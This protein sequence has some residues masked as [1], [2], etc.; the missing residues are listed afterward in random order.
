MNR[1]WLRIPLVVIVLLTGAYLLGP[2]PSV[3]AYD[4]VLPPV[5]A[6]PAALEKYVQARESRH[7]LKPDNEAQITWQD[8][9][10]RKT[11]YSIVYLHGFSASRKEGEPVAPDFAR[12]YGCNL[13]MSRLDGHGIDTSEP[14]LG[15]T[16]AGLWRDA[17][18]ALGIGQTLGHK[19]IV[20][21]TSTGGTLALKLAAEFPDQVYAVINLS[22]N[23][24][25][26]DPL[27]F[28]ADNPWGLQMA[29]WVKK[30]LY[31]HTS[32]EGDPV[33]SRYWYT[34]YR[35]EAVAELE[36]LVESTMTKNTFKK[37]RQ[38]VLN[39]YYY[40][41]EAHQDPTVKVAAILDMEK[42][43]STPAGR[44]AAVAIPGA[45]A[46]VLGSSL[47]SKDIPAV[48][49]AMQHFA[50]EVLNLKPLEPQP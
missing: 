31:N 28:L 23:I 21:G 6:D 33:I 29:R 42:E 25:I 4:T 49:Q 24:A 44:K 5:P 16:A 3:P 15:M 27:A 36:N 17:K 37:I 30:G 39:L 48:E 9:L 7:R 19:V 41:D 12:R 20:M 40:K 34:R 2:A 46:H 18:E 47:T 43:L 35:L 22:P 38:P 10:H 13:Y 26:N 1:K 45:G 32:G 11:P 50:E 8:S 14:L